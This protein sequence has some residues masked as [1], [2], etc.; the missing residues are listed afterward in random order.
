M[1]REKSTPRGAVP[2]SA[3]GSHTACE[4]EGRSLTPPLDLE[5]EVKRLRQEIDSLKK[6]ETKMKRA[7]T[8]KELLALLEEDSDCENAELVD[9][10]YVPP[11]TDEITDEENFDENIIG[12]EELQTDN[13]GAYQ[14]QP[15][16]DSDDDLEDD[17]FSF[18]CENVQIS[19]SAHLALL[20]LNLPSPNVCTFG[21][22]L[23][24]Q[25]GCGDILPKSSVQFVRLP[26]NAIQIAAGS[27]HSV[28]LTLKGEVYT[29]GNAQKGQLGRI[30]GKSSSQDTVQHGQCSTSRYNNP[31]TPWYSFPGPIPNVGPRH[32]RKAT[33]IGASGDQTFLKLDENLINSIS[34][35]K[36]TIVAN[37]NSII[38]LPKEEEIA[39]NFKCIA[40][41][42]KDGVCSSFKNQHQVDFTNKIVCMDHIFNVFWSLNISTTEFIC[43][44]I[45]VSELRTDFLKGLP[46]ILSPELALPAVTDCYVTRFQA[47]INLLCCLDILTTT[48]DL[49]LPINKRDIKDNKFMPCKKYIKEDF[50]SINRFENHGGGWGYSGHSI[51]AIR[52]MTDTDVLLGGF[53]LFGGRG[54]YT[55]KLK[56]IDIGADGGE[57]EIDGE[58]LAETEDIQ[59]ECGPRQKYPVL[60]DE[61]IHIQAHRWYVAWCRI[62]GPSSDCGSSGQTMIITEDQVI[63]YFKSSKK[64]NNGTDVNAGQIPQLLYK[65]ISHENQTPQKPGDVTEST[66]ILSKDFSRTVS[67]ECFKSLLS[68]LQWSWNTF[69]W[70]MVE[71]QSAKNVYD[72]LEL[73]RLVYISK[74]SL[75]LICTYINEIYPRCINKRIPIEN[76][77]LTECVGDTRTLLKQILSD[78]MQTQTEINKSNNTNIFMLN[79]ILDECHNTFVSCFHA[80]YPTA[81]LKWNCLCDLLGEINKDSTSNSQRLPGAVFCALCAPYVRLRNIFPLIGSNTNFENS[82]HSILSSSDNTGLPI[83]NRPDSHHYPILVEQMTYKTQVESNSTPNYQWNDILENLIALAA[84]PVLGK[85]KQCDITT[86]PELSKYCC[87]LLARVVAEL[88]LQCST[89]EEELQSFGRTLYITPSRFTRINQSRTWNTGNGSPDAICFQVDREGISIIGVGVY[90]GIGH[91]EYELELLEDRNK[92]GENQVHSHRWNSLEVS[93]GSYGPEDFAPDIIEIKFGRPVPI[94]ENVKYAI[95]LRNHGGRTSNGDGG[96]TFVRGPDNTT[97]TFSTCSLSFN[98]TTLTRGQI[99]VL[100]YY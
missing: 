86:S 7:L 93:R 78:N 26:C 36:S 40:I 71:G 72:N 97:F 47:A 44:N 90:G 51:E 35:T 46:S 1:D 83:M 88:V 67:K 91:Y 59:Y 12:E 64:S 41:N 32:G 56:L 17:V 42:K 29:F 89:T 9:V 20:G 54:E 3:R 48:Y 21:S 15:S 79:N 33:W 77:A 38:L 49:R 65:I 2:A 96:L 85:L 43:Y 28:V 62:S 31:R 75:R 84:N 73:E 50:Q 14:I 63:F 61:P 57:Q 27:N 98:G 25:L 23:Y 55:A 87:H 99:P 4:G 45:I 58:L 22:N 74:A 8:T 100:L 76:I 69:K 6:A 94:K 16:I 11:E 81:Y 82:F 30:Y 60:F 53:G 92:N 52:F 80:F 24:G 13:A 37:K 95:R 70:G 39:R 18:L 34:I 68:L 10:F 5:R 19:T 66:Y